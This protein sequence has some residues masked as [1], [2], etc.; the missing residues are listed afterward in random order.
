MAEKLELVSTGI[1]TAP[2][3]LDRPWPSMVS[4]L[5][6]CGMAI[7]AAAGCLGIYRELAFLW[8]CWTTDPLRSIGILI[9]PAS[10]VLTLRI[11]RQ[12][13]WE[14]RGTWGGLF[15][16]AL[17]FFLSFLR[18][19][20]MFLAV[21][22]RATLSIIPV[23]LPVYVYGSGIILLF[24]GTR[25]WRNAWFPLGLLLLC[26]PVPFLSNELIDIPLQNVSARVARSFATLIGFAPTT[27]QLRLMFSPNFGMFIAP[28]CN[29]IRGAVTMGYV[30]LILG[31]L[32]RVSA[33]LWIALVAGAVFL[34]YLFN[35]TRLCVLVLYYR[36]A[37][38]HPSMEG[39]AKQADY[40]IGS[41]LFLTAT[42]LFLRLASNKQAKPDPPQVAPGNGTPQPRILNVCIKCAAFA[43]AILLAL[44]LLPLPSDIP[45]RARLHPRSSPAVCRSRSVNSR[46]PALGTNNR[47]ASQLSKMQPTRLRDRTRSFS[48]FG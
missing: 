1:E 30:A 16:I 43:V 31:Y 24:A 2:Q 26:Q 19:N 11:W 6:G 4:F 12:H 5:L 25:V 29:G 8:M 48:A 10:I 38:G 13:G 36:A 39:F 41:C 18:L 7:L 34:G 21:A 33:I 42:L 23:S 22:G 32:K 47:V 14:M 15:V 3:E 37:L 27:P 46:L 17:A 28:G 45:G 9:P 44:A 20:V 35:F 40:F